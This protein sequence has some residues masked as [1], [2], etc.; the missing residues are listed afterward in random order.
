MIS[1]GPTQLAIL[2]LLVDG[3]ARVI[4]SIVEIGVGPL[5]WPDRSTTYDSLRALLRRGLIRRR[6]PLGRWRAT[7]VA[8]DE[9][10]IRDAHETR[11]R[12]DE[13]LARIKT[14]EAQLAAGRAA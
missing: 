6:A 2:R 9:I 10:A 11:R 12:L 7:A 5:G 4:P 3:R 13:A 1:L 14:L 8:C